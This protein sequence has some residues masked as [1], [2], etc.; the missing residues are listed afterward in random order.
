MISYPQVKKKVMMNVQDLLDRNF[1]NRKESVKICA[2]K[3]IRLK[4]Q[5]LTMIK[6]KQIIP[7]KDVI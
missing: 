6:S 4:R 7:E 5:I 3:G 2:E 1:L